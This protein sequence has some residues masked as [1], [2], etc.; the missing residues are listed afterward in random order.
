MSK[1]L[2]VEVMLDG[3]I[4]KKALNIEN[5]I[6]IQNCHDKNDNE[7]QSVIV[8]TNGDVIKVYDKNYFAITKKLDVIA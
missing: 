3:K 5:I 6:S 4:T 1:F 7:T 8:M 2:E